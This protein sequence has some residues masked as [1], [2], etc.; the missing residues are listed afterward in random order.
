MRRTPIVAALRDPLLVAAAGLGLWILLVLLD[1][2]VA[3]LAMGLAPGIAFAAV[4]GPVF[5]EEFVKFAAIV[6]IRLAENRI[7]SALARKDD[8]GS[9]DTREDLPRWPG[10]ALSAIVVFAA[11]ENISYMVRFPAPDTW[12]R[13]LWSLP[14]H[15]AGAMALILAL[16]RG[17]IARTLLALLFALALHLGANLIASGNLAPAILAAGILMALGASFAFGM[18]WLEQLIIEGI[19]IGRK[20]EDRP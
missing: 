11:T 19:H 5:V 1:R 20:H 12:L 7:A 9:V 6:A 17:G 16:W 14:V 13:L 2:W 15:L 10:L 8:P 4:A 18:I 3:G